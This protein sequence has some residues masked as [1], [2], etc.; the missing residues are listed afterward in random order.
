MKMSKRNIFDQLQASHSTLWLANQ[1]KKEILASGNR[2]INI[3]GF[4]Q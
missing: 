1:V 2:N 4:H 3:N